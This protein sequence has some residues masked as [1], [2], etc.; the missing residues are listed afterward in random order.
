MPQRGRHCAAPLGREHGDAATRALNGYPC[1][2][3]RTSAPGAG[4]EV[5][6]DNFDVLAIGVVNGTATKV[7]VDVP[8]LGSPQTTN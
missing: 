3:E 5:Q 1:R 7:H 8:V 2:R 6:C 4:Y